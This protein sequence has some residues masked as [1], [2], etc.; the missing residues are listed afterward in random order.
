MSYKF[1]AK[2]ALLSIIS[3]NS[4]AGEAKKQPIYKKTGEISGEIYTYK[5]EIKI[6]DA[7]KLAK[8]IAANRYEISSIN[9]NSPGGNVNEAILMGELIK[10]ARLDTWV[11]PGSICA[12]ACFFMW[13][14]GANRSAVI[15]EQVVRNAKT[16]KYVS[17]KIGLHRPYMT[18]MTNDEISLS[19]QS[20]LVKH[21]DAYLMGKGLPRRLI[22]LM[23]SRPSNDIYWITEEDYS[24]IGES[25]IELEE[26]Y[27]SKCNDTRRKLYQQIDAARR[28]NDRNIEPILLEKIGSINQCIDNLNAEVRQRNISEKFPEILKSK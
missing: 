13:I 15:G 16:G 11:Q 5:G 25:P 19:N 21:V 23:M 20:K 4:Y 6:G 1:L 10:A 9:L 18:S 14:N 8:F 2:I 22:D 17:S 3:L 12:S 27:I 7:A 28:N 26:L 24:E